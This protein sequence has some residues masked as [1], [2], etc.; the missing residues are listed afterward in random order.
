MKAKIL[1]TSALIFVGLGFLL[2]FQTQNTGKLRMIFCDVGEGDGM[3]LIL[4]SGKQVVVDGGP[5]SKILECLSSNMPFS[6]H[7]VDMIIAT[8]AQKDHME[9]LLFVLERYEVTNVVDTTLASEALLY[10]EWSKLVT[11]EGAKIVKGMRGDK[12]VLDENIALSVLW[13]PNTFVSRWQTDPPNDLNESSYV[14][15]LDFAGGCAYLTGDIP[16]EILETVIDRPCDILK[17]SHH[18]SKT[19]TS[20]QVL[21]KAKPRLAVIQVGKNSYGHPT[22]EVLDLLVGVNVLR[23][24]LMGTIEID[25]DGNQLTINK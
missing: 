14:M 18:G 20:A 5:G 11:A 8:H 4:P 17:V 22:R 19:G 9:G 13:P 24:D 1:V 16:K 3:L 10:K 23:N 21:E 6:D 25:S 2:I 15:R 12:F 7:S